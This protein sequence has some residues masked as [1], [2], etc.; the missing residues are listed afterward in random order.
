MK[1][2]ELKTSLLSHIKDLKPNDFYLLEGKL[3]FKLKSNADIVKKYLQDKDY[4]VVQTS[5][6]N[7]EHWQGKYESILYFKDL[8][9]ESNG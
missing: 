4:K 6:R 8:E 3:I 5:V 2:I 9:K 7:W 1:Y